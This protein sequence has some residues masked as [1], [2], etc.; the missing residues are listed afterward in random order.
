MKYLQKCRRQGNSMTYC[1]D[2]ANSIYNQD[3][4]EIW[5]KDCILPFRKTV[6][7][8][9]LRTMTAKTYNTLLLNYLKPEIEKILRKNQNG[10][11][12]K[13]SITSQILTIHQII[14]GVHAKNL[15]ATLLFVNFS[16]AFDCTH[17]EDGAN[18]TSIWPPQR[19]YHSHN[20]DL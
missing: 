12:R 6:T 10:F 8:E 11:L 20:D 2:T 9:L 16:K 5:T 19:N 15:K 1:S 3:T 18:T 17:W 4:I 7:L 13:W 14:E